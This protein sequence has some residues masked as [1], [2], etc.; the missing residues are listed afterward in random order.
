ME[1]KKLQNGAVKAREVDSKQQAP[2]R[3]IWSRR[4]SISP[5]FFDYSIRI[6]NGKTS[7]RC[8]ITEGKVGSKHRSLIAGMTFSGQDPFLSFKVRAFS[9]KNQ[10]FTRAPVLQRGG[11]SA[12]G[13]IP[14]VEMVKSVGFMQIHRPFPFRLN[15]WG[16]LEG[17]F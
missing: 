10:R 11:R 9:S 8:N 12:R 3:K 15:E 2:V 5:E 13:V 4:S 17:A 16:G 1:E 14:G 6:Y 7:V